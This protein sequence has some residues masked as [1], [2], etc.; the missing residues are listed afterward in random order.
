MT[1]VTTAAEQAR[2]T[3]ETEASREIA[4]QTVPDAANPSA[5]EA[6]PADPSPQGGG[7]ARDERSE[8]KPLERATAFDHSRADIA[9][10]FREKRAAAGGQVDFH[11]DMRDPSQTYGP[12]A[13]QAQ[14]DTSPRLRG[15]VDA[16]KR[17]RVRG[18]SQ[19][20]RPLTGPLTPTLSPQAGR[21]SLRRRS[22]FG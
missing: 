18:D 19:A 8:Q 2:L 14:D 4:A 16:A 9:A 3:A 1:D 22:S 17:R 21:G 13:P 6:A 7:E 11:G 5:P 15:E 20:L 12:Y 10:R